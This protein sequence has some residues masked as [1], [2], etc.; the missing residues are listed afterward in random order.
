M[1]NHYRRLLPAA[2]IS[3]CVV[4]GLAEPARALTFT[5]FP[6]PGPPSA[7]TTGPDSALWFI[8]RNQ[9]GRI[10]PAGMVSEFP[11]PTTNSPAAGI[12]TCPDGAPEL[13]GESGGKSVRITTRGIITKT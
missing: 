4:A 11:I 13:T 9:I 8:E 1:Q 7:I 10:T 5:E 2:T 3:L 12:P 6:T